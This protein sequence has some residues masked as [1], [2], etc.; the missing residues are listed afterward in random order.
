MKNTAKKWNDNGEKLTLV[1]STYSNNGLPYFGFYT[2]DGEPYCD[3]SCNTE[4]NEKGTITLDH[5][6]MSMCPSL[7][8]QFV[9]RYCGKE[10]EEISSGFITMP[11]YELK[12]SIFEEATEL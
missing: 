7:C 2:K 12:D 6:F 1:R 11:K 4:E 5:N 9:E 8:V 10:I 3:I